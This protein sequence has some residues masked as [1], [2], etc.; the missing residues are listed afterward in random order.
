MVLIVTGIIQIHPEDRDRVI[1]PATDMAIETR[2]EDGCITYAFY[3]DI[4][5]PGRLRVYEEW[6]DQAALDA[7]AA[8]AHMAVWRA[9]LGELRVLSRDVVKF[10][11]ST[12]EQ[13]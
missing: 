5:T 6:R 2:K 3:E 10:P 4:E 1:G 13:L 8:S 9:A 11:N 12:A 7:H